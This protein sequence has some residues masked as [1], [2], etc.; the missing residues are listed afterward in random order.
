MKASPAV[1]TPAAQH[2]LA[3]MATAHQAMPAELRQLLNRLSEN[4][5]HVT[6]VVALS[7]GPRVF[8]DAS[9]VSDTEVV[10][11]VLT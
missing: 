8:V 3:T 7:F 10:P 6:V 4:G 1:V 2:T 5:C 11:P 9:V